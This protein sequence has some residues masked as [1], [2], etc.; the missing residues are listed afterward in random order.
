MLKLM[1]K[2]SDDQKEWTSLLNAIVESIFEGEE[3]AR[4]AQAQDDLRPL[5]LEQ[6][7][8]EFMRLNKIVENMVSSGFFDDADVMSHKKGYLKFQRPEYEDEKF[9]ATLIVARPASLSLSNSRSSSDALRVGMY[10]ASLGSTGRRRAGLSREAVH[11]DVLPTALGP[12]D[13]VCSLGEGGEGIPG[14]RH[15]AQPPPHRPRPRGD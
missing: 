12:D 13:R 14:G 1:A 6:Q 3:L 8:V 9:Y 15:L 7:C 10:Y 11:E 2:T 5:A 4:K